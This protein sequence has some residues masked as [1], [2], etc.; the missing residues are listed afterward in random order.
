MNKDNL[1]FATIG[2]LLGFIGGYLMHEVMVARQPPR[3][4]A[5]E[6]AQ[7]APMAQGGEAGGGDAANG[8]APNAAAGVGAPVGPDGGAAG[9]GAPMAEIQALREQVAKN[10]KDADAVLKLAGMNFQIQNWQRARDLFQQY[11]N[12][13]PDDP[14]A[15]SDLGICYQELGDLQQALDR[16]HRAQKIAPTHWQSRYNEVI[17]LATMNR[18]D[19]AGKVLKELQKLQPDNPNVAKLASEL[20]QRRKAA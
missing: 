15:L 4:S 14:D 19:E 17:A 1:L 10:P 6:V 7:A 11:L 2:V 9:G 20:D 18:F 13:R 12:L 16:F 5:G 3:R 8:G